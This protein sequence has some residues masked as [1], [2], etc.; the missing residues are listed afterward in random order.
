MQK[1]LRFLILAL[2][3]EDV[4]CSSS[5][6][7]MQRVSIQVKVKKKTSSTG[8]IYWTGLFMLLACMRASVVSWIHEIEAQCSDYICPFTRCFAVLPSTSLTLN[9]ILLAVFH[10]VWVNMVWQILGYFLFETYMMQM[11]IS[12][13][14]EGQCLDILQKCCSQSVA[15]VHLSGFHLLKIS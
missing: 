6:R 4:S 15:V 9:S 12:S 7:L 5:S 11:T 3:S 10:V 1:R 14:F 2:M 13:Y 8:S